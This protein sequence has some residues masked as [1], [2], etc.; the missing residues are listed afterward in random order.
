MAAWPQP[1]AHGPARAPPV[2][3]TVAV[4]PPARDHEEGHRRRGLVHTALGEEAA[5]G[6]GGL[7]RVRPRARYPQTV[8]TRERAQAGPRPSQSSPPT[9]HQAAP[10]PQTRKAPPPTNAIESAGGQLRTGHPRNLGHYPPP[11]RPRSNH[12]GNQTRNSDQRAQERDKDQG[13]PASKPT[14]PHQGHTTTNRRTNPSTNPPPPTPTGP[15]PTPN[16]HTQKNRQAP[17][18]IASSRRARRLLGSQGMAPRP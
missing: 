18:R 16:P 7:R 8:A 5:G 17:G 10:P 9:G 15:P 11:T 14:A 6:L 12:C 4:R 2:R 3:P 1:S 13:E